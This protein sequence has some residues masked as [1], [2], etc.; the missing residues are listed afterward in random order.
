MDIPNYGEATWREYCSRRLHI[1]VERVKGPALVGF[2][3]LVLGKRSR[4]SL[5]T[6]SGRVYTIGHKPVGREGMFL[7]SSVTQAL[8]FNENGECIDHFQRTSR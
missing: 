6:Y 7:D 1:I 4:I 2:C 8:I 3:G 5:N